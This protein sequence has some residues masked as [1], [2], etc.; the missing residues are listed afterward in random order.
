MVLVRRSFVNRP[1]TATEAGCLDA[2]AA[3][4][5]TLPAL[6]LLCD[7]LRRSSRQA[8]FLQASGRRAASGSTGSEEDGG[9]GG[10]GDE[11]EPGPGNQ[12]REMCDAATAYGQYVRRGCCNPRRLLT[13][14]EERQALLGHSVERPPLRRRLPRWGSGP[15]VG[16]QVPPGWASAVQCAE[17]RLA[18]MVEDAPPPAL[19]D[20]PLE[21]EPGAETPRSSAAQGGQ[22]GGGTARGVAM[23]A[24]MRAELRRS[25]EAQGRVSEPTLR[26]GITVQTLQTQLRE[27]REAAT[28]LREA[29]EAWLAEASAAEPPPDSPAA[30]HSEAVRLLRACGRAPAPTAAELLRTTW[31]GSAA[32]S[33]TAAAA[34]NVFI[35]LSTADAAALHAGALTWA[36][37]VVLEGRLLRAER[38]A[39][40]AAHNAVGAA[41]DLA[42]ELR[43]R[44]VWTPA[45]HPRWLALEV[46]AGLQIWP[47]QYQVARALLQS[48]GRNR[49]AQLNM[50][51]C[52]RLLVAAPVLQP[53]LPPPSVLRCRHAHACAS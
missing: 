53:L 42:R 18:A 38:M 49:V 1:L 9:G 43:L 30:W 3:L 10:A 26:P 15:V 28:A 33:R 6:P 35:G 48:S 23:A 47:A 27:D 36:Q 40:A 34:L 12:D 31:A 4:G 32:A 20:F 37:A 2:C 52:S 13:A 16:L 51:A 25:W 17:E 39:A 46:D 44:R 19:G 21:A 45:E 24:E 5:A 14:V 41:R 7:L 8:S 29:C 11:A 22:H 50:G